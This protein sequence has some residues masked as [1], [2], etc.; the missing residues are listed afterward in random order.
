MDNAIMYKLDEVMGA[1]SE[2]QAKLNMVTD[3]IHMLLNIQLSLKEEIEKQQDL[4]QYIRS[5]IEY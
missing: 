3:E 1:L 2:N 5:M 4:L